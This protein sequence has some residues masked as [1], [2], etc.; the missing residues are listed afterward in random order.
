M[1]KIK[2][3]ILSIGFLWLQALLF[4][5]SA[6]CEN[7]DISLSAT[8]T[9]A[10]CYSNGVITV[11]VGGEDVG[12]L[13]LSDAEFSLMP[14]NGGVVVDWTKWAG[15]GA[16]KT[17][18]T[19]VSGVYR[20]QM[21]AFCYESNEWTTQN[22]TVSVTVGG[23]YKPMDFSA[24]MTRKS[25]NC[26][27]TGKIEMSF[28]EG[29]PPY[30]ITIEAPSGYEGNRS[31]VD[32]SSSL[33]SLDD[34][35]SGEYSITAV[36]AC[37]Y[38]DSKTF[39]VTTVENDVPATL[40]NIMIRQ[41][42]TTD[43]ESI[44][45]Y[46]AN[47]VSDPDEQYYWDNSSTYYEYAYLANGS[48]DKKW[49]P[50]PNHKQ[51]VFEVPGGYANF[52]APENPPS[53]VSCI[54]PKGCET[55]SA[56]HLL[57]HNLVYICPLSAMFNGNTLPGDNCNTAKL[58]LGVS[59][60]FAVCYP[61][62]LTVTDTETDVLK[63]QKYL[64]GNNADN[65]ISD[66]TT[67]VLYIRDN[68]YEIILKS[69]AD[70]R[71]FRTTWTPAM[72]QTQTLAGYVEFSNGGY[73][74]TGNSMF[75]ISSSCIRLYTPAGDNILPGTTIE[76]VEGPQQTIGMMVKNETIH[77][78]PEDYNSSNFY[79][80]NTTVPY[81]TPT[82]PIITPG[83]YKFQITPP[84]AGNTYTIEVVKGANY[85][86]QD[87][88]IT[89]NKELTCNGLK[90]TQLGGLQQIMDETGKKEPVSAYF[91]IMKAPA[92]VA[93]NPNYVAQN[94]ELLLPS[95]GT[96]TIGMMAP[97]QQF[98]TCTIATTDI[99][100]DRGLH[101]NP[102]NIS[103]FHCEGNDY[104]YINVEAINGIGPYTYRVTSAEGTDYIEPQSNNTGEFLE[105]GF[106]GGTYNIEVT[107]NACHTSFSI[108]VTMLDL[109]NA[110]IAY[111]GDA[112]LDYGQGVFCENSAILINCVSLGKDTEYE[113]IG[114]NGFTS[115]DR[116]PR[117][118]AKYPESEGTY[119]VT[120]R[121]TGCALPMD[122]PVDVYILPAP[123]PLS[124]ID[125][126][127]VCQHSGNQN[128]V[129]LSEVSASSGCSL[130]WY[131]STDTSIPEPTAHSTTTVGTTEY[132][133]S[134]VN[135]SGC[136]SERTKISVIVEN[137]CDNLDASVEI[138]DAAVVC[139]GE[140][141]EIGLL[142]LTEDL[143]DKFTY[144]WATPSND[145]VITNAT[146]PSAQITSLG[147]NSEIPLS[148]TVT[149]ACGNET[150]L[151]TT[152]IVS[153]IREISFDGLTDGAIYCRESEPIELTPSVEGGVFTGAGIIP[154][155]NYFS[156]ALVPATESSTTI[157]YSVLDADGVCSSFC[158]QTV[159]IGQKDPTLQLQ[160]AIETQ[161]A[162]CDGSA[163]SA[164]FTISGGD[165]NY[166]YTITGEEESTATDEVFS[167][168]LPAGTYTITVWQTNDRCA[169]EVSKTFSIVKD[170][171][172]VTLTLRHVACPAATDGEIIAD[173]KG[174]T[175]PYRYS[176]ETNL[177][178][179][180]PE[181]L[182][183][184][185]SCTPSVLFRPSGSHTFD[186]LAMGDYKVTVIDANG[187]EWETD[188]EI[189]A[190]GLVYLSDVLY[191]SCFG[192]SDGEISIQAYQPSRMPETVEVTAD[193]R[194]NIMQELALPGY[195]YTWKKVGDPNFNAVP[196]VFPLEEFWAENDAS[197]IYKGVSGI[198]N[199]QMGDYYSEITTN[200][201][202][203]EF[204]SPVIEVLNPNGTLEVIDVKADNPGKDCKLEDQRIEITLKGGWED[205][206]IFF[207]EGSPEDA[208]KQ[209][210][211]GDDGIGVVDD[212]PLYDE[213]PG[214]QYDDYANVPEIETYNDAN[215]QKITIYKTE[216]LAPG[217]YCVIVMDTLGCMTDIRDPRFQFKIDPKITLK[218]NPYN[219]LICARDSTGV[220]I[221]AA[222][223]GATE[224]YIY[225]YVKPIEDELLR[226][227]IVELETDVETFTYDKLSKGVYSFV[228][229][230]EGGECEGFGS[231]NITDDKEPLMLAKLEQTDIRCYGDG[232][233]GELLVTAVGGT[234]TED[235]P[236][237]FEFKGSPD[238]VLEPENE[239]QEN[240]NVTNSK[241]TINRLRFTGIGAG[242]NILIVFDNAGCTSELEFE[243]IQPQ[244]LEVGAVKGSE[245]CP[246]GNG[247]LTLNNVSGGT[248]PY[249]YSLDTDNYQDDCILKVGTGAISIFPAILP[250]FVK[251]ANDCPAEGQGEIRE[252]TT[253]LPK[254]DF[255][256]STFGYSSDVLAVIDI[257][258]E[259][260]IGVTRDSVRFYID[261]EMIYQEDPRIY[262]YG[263]FDETG[264]IPE[265]IGISGDVK[266]IIVNQET[267]QE[268][269]R[270][271]NALKNTLPKNE[272]EWNREEW[273]PTDIA[274][275]KRYY[276][277]KLIDDALKGY[278]N[279]YPLD[280]IQRMSFISLR[281]DSLT[282]ELLQRK[283]GGDDIL[284]P[285]NITMKVY[286]S[287]GCDDE[288]TKPVAIVN[289][290]FEP[291][292][293]I[294]QKQ[295]DILNLTVVPNPVSRNDGFRIEIEFG[296][297]VDFYISLVDISGKRIVD[298]KFF[299]SEEHIKLINGKMM[300]VID[301][302]QLGN[303]IQLSNSAVVRVETAAPNRDV[304]AAVIL[305]KN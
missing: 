143:L 298:N 32:I 267:K 162:K 115:T 177:S 37:G 103:A 220:I 281:S 136:E 244:E 117:P 178:D 269:E 289:D 48:G 182:S 52:C 191:V 222:E 236:Y 193:N 188:T 183:D 126:I 224:R 59:P 109:A 208:L 77:T 279:L 72:T 166:T 207:L 233:T 111:A 297:E 28:K 47:K 214:E 197:Y 108:P 163:G 22:K 164:G 25:M 247:R 2:L 252:S 74:C 239:G 212:K 260:P 280:V 58:S 66:A 257:T 286:Y 287:T 95:P 107:D 196:Q 292:P 261:N 213:K 82:Y 205:Y 232:A 10:S 145:A 27:P 61:A 300:A 211:Y 112:G 53:L 43:C 278:E 69:L 187:C 50:L 153:G 4:T 271:W 221:L 230:E 285:F 270:L 245:I 101:I 15:E 203:C 161:N 223:G 62:T 174:E 246:D 118:I 11:T 70:G 179:S 26:K 160:I 137:C 237:I 99:V 185:S 154:G 216:I 5:A 226:N 134:Q 131:N 24:V 91:R 86:V 54:R 135:G 84:C 71:E 241:V 56:E 195:A 122:E 268:I 9:D 130:R 175:G 227:K 67:D 264:L 35:P 41:P 113:W 172:D 55:E 94:G 228:A 100:Y 200:Y 156:P 31:F 165:K 123:L 121:P 83:T 155:S 81:N 181:N 238:N 7:I 45:P 282:A 60:L 39:T 144:Q 219:G 250:V 90:L 21:R 168:Y 119:T 104:G 78:I 170:S 92:G 275:E 125:N 199:L 276:E 120:V 13:R 159:H 146:S 147:Y 201:G 259:P 173:V 124:A 33:F 198:K 1:A 34:V 194:S 235:Q 42:N 105:I 206:H 97:G 152:L 291:Y 63:F 98:N 96:Y 148:V 169:G 68:T 294:A 248:K 85:D 18:N 249:K 283:E 284:L 293:D 243:I 151:N 274:L 44:I 93:F 19:A 254:P 141:A 76:Y 209:I 79:L 114:P 110:R 229:K 150:L 14:L 46:E 234:V 210:T 116:T 75:P 202:L 12:N 215:G 29:T 290:H 149:D 258:L 277:M 265:Q 176:V 6:Q 16:V 127:R 64:S 262:T 138:N 73:Y 255:L 167:K 40:Y 57:E 295:Q 140:S 192:R 189:V 36:D 3:F 242:E 288:M 218:D 139:R 49:L 51:P 190:E 89:Y 217:D 38:S 171:L 80:T 184:Y 23:N 87:I 301:R 302:K 296:N 129:T 30:S 240:L 106:A 20:L 65:I 133:V 305:V 272:E 204:K 128:I 8:A 186:N 180:L 303:D 304:A 266:A 142:N 17:Y 158:E 88:N 256:V 263:N 225:S 231:F 299:K 102:E 251:D 132:F 273:T 253:E 157:R